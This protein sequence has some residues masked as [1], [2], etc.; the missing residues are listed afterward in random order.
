M[1]TDVTIVYPVLTKLLACDSSLQAKATTPNEMPDGKKV[2][3]YTQ[4]TKSKNFEGCI[5]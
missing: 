2:V 4:E 3:S 1:S 5:Q